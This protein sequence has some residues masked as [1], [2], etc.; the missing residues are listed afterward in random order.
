VLDYGYEVGQRYRVLGT[1][2][3]GAHADVYRAYDAV[4][5][6]EVALKVFRDDA[7]DAQ[8]AEAA[9]Q[10]MVAEG[11]AILPLYEVHPDLAEGQ[12]TVMPLMPDTLASAARLLVTQALRYCRRVLTAL[13]FCHGRGVVHGDVK[14]ANLFVDE[15][16]QLL[17]G[18]FGVADAYGAGRR[19]FTLEYAAPELLEG[20]PRSEA[21]D[22]WATAVTLYE[23]IVRRMPFGSRPEESEEAIARRVG[24]GDYRH[25]DELLP[26]LP[27]SFREL[28]K[29]CFAPDPLARGYT[30][31]ASLRNAIADLV[32]RVEWD[33]IGRAD[34]VVCFEGFEVTSDGQFTGVQYEA[35]VRRLGRGDRHAA[36]LKRRT[37]AGGSLRRLPGL[38]D[39]VGSAAQ[40]GQQLS[41]WMR[42][43]TMGASPAG[44]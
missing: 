16:Q 9:R 10:F 3:S 36:V 11:G 25:P 17:L 44:R 35:A 23:L 21:T 6:G 15:T 32:V 30:T 33:R 27:L 42:R 41:V 1:L 31:A 38:P 20:Q 7:M 40:A 12:I 34:S 14:P 24:S 8:T 43:L 39:H 13:E 19:G 28:F 18:D 2:G 29:G 4:R 22:T 26:F 37:T 5:G